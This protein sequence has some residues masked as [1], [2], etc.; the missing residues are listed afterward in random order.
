MALL[1]VDDLSLQYIASTI[2]GTKEVTDYRE[3]SENRITKLESNR[4]NIPTRLW[5]YYSIFV[6]LA[7]FVP[8][9]KGYAH[10]TCAEIT[11]LH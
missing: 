4:T 1:E 3:H 11:Y 2:P 10:R 9:N 8:R 6:K 7:G 5:G